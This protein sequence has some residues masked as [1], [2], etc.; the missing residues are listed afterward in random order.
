MPEPPGLRDRGVRLLLLAALLCEVAAWIALEG[1]NL[2]DTVEY[3]ALA[4]QLADGHRLAG[5][6]HSMRA[7]LYP[8]LLAPLALLGRALDL[9]DPRW[10]V[11]AARA[12]HAACGLAFVL[13]AAR[14]GALLWDR[15]AGLAAGFL[16]AV[17]PVFLR[18]C[19]D[20]LPEIPAGILLGLAA[21]RALRARERAWISGAL[22]GLAVLLSYK[23][24]PIAALLGLCLV[25]RDRWR[26]RSS[27]LGFGAALGAVLAA[28]G[29]LDRLVYGAWWLSLRNYLAYNVSSV[30]F[31][32]L[33]RLGLHDAAG[34]VL[35]FAG[36]YFGR[37]PDSSAE[38]VARRVERQSSVAWY[39]LHA[40]EFLVWPALLLAALGLWTCLRRRSAPRLAVLALLGAFI[41]VLSGK[42]AKSFRLML[43][44]LP[45]LA[46]LAGLGCALLWEASGPGR[47]AGR[48]AAAVLL[49]LSPVL[50]AREL[51]L[52]G[53]RLH[54]AYWRAV[55]WMEAAAAGAGA[56]AP[57]R[58]AAADRFAVYRRFSRPFELAELRLPAEWRGQAGEA[59]IDPMTLE[60]ALS[61][62]DWLLLPETV[63]TERLPLLDPV[64]R[65]F[66][67]EA[68][69]FE[70]GNAPA[71]GAVCVFRRAPPGSPGR[72]FSALLAPGASGAPPGAVAFARDAAGRAAERL[73]LFG[74]GCEELPGDGLPWIT[75]RWSTDT[76]LGAPCRLRYLVQSAEGELLREGLLEVGRGAGGAAALSPG[77]VLVDGRLERGAARWRRA[78]EAWRPETHATSP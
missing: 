56:G 78:I 19:L 26:L 2:A 12:A 7:P 8:L 64:N 1:Y 16:A 30:L 5:T 40:P 41:V 43:P 29:A 38:G 68:A 34:A 47:R 44:A 71:L 9:A 46:A 22:A 23:A 48:G 32:L 39:A 25:A 28:G 24:L 18:Y 53:P 17:N 60:R 49:L 27:W 11:T 57:Q 3:L 61:S 65:L 74:Y 73:T 6:L 58:F 42:D 33:G 59:D 21:E 10:V 50:G 52:A 54:G 14:L 63:L 70:P 31:G 72:R 77:A 69:F 75:W 55:A 67:L 35:E 76:G 4:D 62:L 45:F 20:P 15:R 13:V 36:H 66:T 37:E 51:A